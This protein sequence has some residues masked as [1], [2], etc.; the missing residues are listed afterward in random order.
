MNVSLR[1]RTCAQVI[2]LVMLPAAVAALVGPASRAA[3]QSSL[4]Y[5]AEAYEGAAVDAPWRERARVRIARHRTAPLVIRV[6]DGEGRPRSDV[7][8][9]VAMEEHAFE[10]GSAVTARMLASRGPDA[11]RYRA[12]VKSRLTRAVFENDL[13]WGPWAAGASNTDER[14]RREWVAAAFDSLSA[15]SVDVRGHYGVWGPLEGGSV[16]EDLTGDT[17]P[18]ADQPRGVR[19]AWLRNL[20]ERIP[21]VESLGRPG[22]WDAIN[23]PVGWGPP[24]AGEVAGFGLYAAAIARMRELAPRAQLW[25]NEGGVLEG[26]TID[27]YV[28]AL[29][30]LRGRGVRPDGIGVMGHIEP[31]LP[32]PADLY[33]RLDR[34]AGIAPHLQVT[35]LDVTV[36]SD[37]LQARY[38]RDVLIAAY[39]HP[40]VEGVLL[41][42]FWA[43]RHWRPEAALYGEDWRVRP[44]LRAVDELLF[45]RWWTET[46][47]ETDAVGRFSTSGYVGRYEVRALRG[48]ERTVRT[49]DLDRDGSRITLVLD[50]DA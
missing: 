7:R 35:E 1:A 15:W 11:R 17:I 18:D 31:P 42:G 50:G 32:P 4:G 30:R 46:A 37:T 14:F 48:S 6:V 41:W 39:S 16:P 36:E 34:L 8:V 28:R 47:G 38:L 49:V 2:F 43:G 5:G 22:E 23:H 21:A 3:A 29:E 25:I 12:F 10:F 26:E 20:E 27:A 44:A 40:D 45:E 13:K 33:A 19:R 9:E 24:T